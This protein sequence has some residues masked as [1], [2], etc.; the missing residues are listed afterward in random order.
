MKT[1]EIIKK[2]KHEILV[3]DDTPA[4]LRLLTDILIDHGYRVR[5]ASDGRL[6]IRSVGIDPPDLILLD[7]KMRNMDGYEV[8]RQLKANENSREVPVIFISALGETDSIVEGFNAGGVDYITKPFEAEEVLARINIHLRIR[9]LT[10]YL[11]DNVRL[12]TAKLETT[13]QE[14]REQI[15]ERKK[16]ENTLRKYE[17]I[18]STTK[19]LLSLIDRKYIY[20]AVNNAYLEVH[21]K[22]HDLIIGHSISELMGAKVFKEKIK[23]NI[24]RS[25]KGEQINYKEW[26]D[27]DELGQRYMDVTY[28]PYF[29]VDG[30][31]SAVVINSRDIT[32]DIRMQEIIIQ[33]EKM[34][35]MGGLAAGMAHEINNPLAGIIQTANVI[36]SRL[37]KETDMQ[38]NLKAAE[39]EGTSMEVIRNF[40]M[41]RRIPDMIS[42]IIESGKRMTEIISNMLSFACKSDKTK[43]SEDLTELLDK[44][45]ELAANDYNLKKHYD[46]KIIEIIKEY[47]DNLPS[48]TCEGV[49]IQQVILNILINGAQA[50]QKGGINK[51]RFIIRCREEDSREWICLEIE[52]NGPGMTK[53]ICDRIFEPFFTT[54]PEGAGTGLG[55][56]VSYFIITENHDGD[57]AVESRPGLGTKF[58]IRLPL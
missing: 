49:K 10:E 20:Q 55:L 18:V 50:M 30:S 46:F 16:A 26:F 8:C 19:D 56:S 12:R 58:I 35:S 6:A 33:S 3:V 28:Y 48:V 36:A 5:P 1:H 47:E 32:E 42:T 7:V 52:D 21:R 24:D 57:I 34:L 14:L 9:E 37:Y 13:N 29:E 11:E 45:Q 2:D 38:A 4:S 17:L 15:S 31:V 44:A 51:P 40:M 22:R 54:K 27:F 23:V 53:A 25:F 39:E 41:A 43:S